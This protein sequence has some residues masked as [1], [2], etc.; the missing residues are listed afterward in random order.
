MENN[1]VEESVRDY[2]SEAMVTPKGQGDDRKLSGKGIG[3]GRSS[4][5]GQGNT[6]NVFPCF[7]VIATSQ[8]PGLP[9]TLTS[10]HTSRDVPS[11]IGEVIFIRA[12][13]NRAGI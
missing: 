7:F 13:K 1:A 12:Q 8:S 5:D 4:G 3:F 9:E 11:G 2:L 6:V 10:A